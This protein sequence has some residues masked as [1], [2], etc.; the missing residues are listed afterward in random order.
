MASRNLQFYPYCYHKHLSRA[1]LHM[2]SRTLA[3]APPEVGGGGLLASSRFQPLLAFANSFLSRDWSPARNLRPEARGSTPSWNSSSGGSQMPRGHVFPWLRASWS[4]ILSSCLIRYPS[5][6]STCSVLF[7]ASG[8]PSN[9]LPE[10]LVSVLTT[11]AVVLGGIYKSGW[12]E[13]LDNRE[14]TP[15]LAVVRK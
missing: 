13:A 6:G 14:E 7:L 12:Q 11:V 1:C 9:Q 8:F 10:H 5:I 3:Y 15:C 4:H 2:P